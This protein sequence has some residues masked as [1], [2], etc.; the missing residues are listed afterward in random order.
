M[1]NDSWYTYCSHSKRC[2]Y[3]ESFTHANWRLLSIGMNMANISGV[4]FSPQSRAPQ[5]SYLDYIR[6]AL[7]ESSNLLPLR[8][9]LLRLPEIWQDFAKGQPTVAA[10]E[11]GLSYARSFSLWIET[12]DTSELESNMSGIVTLPLLTTIHVVQY[13]QYLQHAGITHSEF[14]N[15]LHPC[16]VQGFCAGLMAA[17]VIAVSKDETDLIENAAK[18]IRISLGIGAFGEIGSDSVSLGSTTMVVR[19]RSGAEATQITREFPEV[20]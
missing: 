9:S 8:D 18:A 4:I 17:M 7:N 13:V 15:T 11:H 20:R 16:G 2:K 3:S 5:K 19:L 1:F 14:I 6:A 10:L 12:G